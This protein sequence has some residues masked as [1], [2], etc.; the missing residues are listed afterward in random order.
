M[1]VLEEDPQGALAT[2]EP[3]LASDDDLMFSRGSFVSSIALALLGRG[4]EAVSVAYR[5]LEVHRRASGGTQQP[6]AQL[7]GAVFGHASA[8]RFARA[9]ADAA[10]G[11]QN[12]LASGD[13][14]AQ[15]TFLF[16]AGWVLVERGQLARAL[17]AFLDGASVNREIRD[18]AALRWCL[19]GIALA[20]AMGGHVDQAV[21]AAAERDEL[22]VGSLTVYESDLTERSR[23]WVSAC[24]G[25]L[26]RAREILAAAVARAAAGQ[27]RIAEARLLHDLARLGQPGEVASRLAELAELVDGE[28]VAA[29]AAHVGALSRGDAAGIDAAGRALD[30]LGASLL[31]AEAYTAAAAAYRSAGLVRLATA[32]S[33]RAAELAA[34]C[35][36]VHTPG[37]AP[38]Q[39]PGRL[40]P[41]ER[42]VAGLAAAGASSREIAARLVL[43]V[44]TV[45]NH[46]QSAYTKLG[47][48]SRDELARVLES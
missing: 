2:A 39:A 28:F 19:S 38:G 23:A 14:D 36:D 24:T 16:Q 10:T 27:L 33:R 6:E 22:P 18:L 11:Y 8:G 26:S 43:S 25:E 31:A 17:G 41:R 48:S 12:S 3:L 37:L 9:E 35:G 20:E 45:D 7:I 46:L 1:M 44:R 29:L 13:K 30:A 47:V 40:T 42:E 32:A 34:A 21:A 15:A 4:D 5:G